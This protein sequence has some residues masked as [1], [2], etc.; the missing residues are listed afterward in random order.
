MLTPTIRA[1]SCNSKMRCGK[2]T[3]YQRIL[4]PLTAHPLATVVTS[5]PMSSCLICHQTSH[6][7]KRPFAM[8]ALLLLPNAR[9]LSRATNA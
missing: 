5:F 1:N 7:A 4:T 9:V 3:A 2:T 6:Q 8:F